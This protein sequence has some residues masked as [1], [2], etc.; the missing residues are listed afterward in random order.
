MAY[1]L[2][3]QDQLDALKTWWKTHGNK[4]TNVVTAVLFV[5]VAFQAW[6]IYQN[7]QILAASTKYEQLTQTSPK[8][9][10][11]AQSISG[12]LIEHYASTPYAGRAALWVAK[13]NYEAKDVKS[14]KAQLEWAS[15]YAKEDAIKA[16]ASIQ[17][18]GLQLE[19]KQFDL[20]LKTLESANH[21]GF[22]GLVSDLKGDI[23]A[24]QGKV[25]EA[26]KAYTE[27]IANL[28]TRG[29]YGKYTQ[30]KLEALGS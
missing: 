28:D 16:M 24:A 3:E 27:A 10:K 6:T 21:V 19:E 5:F 30:R 14:A 9:I 1:D 23:Y 4:V 15:Q 12:D 20:A 26:K 18:A 29:R 22:E 8:E 2:E 11:A 17:L 25:D 7:R 13:A